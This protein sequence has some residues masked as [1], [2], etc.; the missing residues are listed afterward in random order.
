MSKKISPQGSEMCHWSIPF[1]LFFREKIHA[2]ITNSKFFPVYQIYS[3]QQ[4]YKRKKERGS[5]VL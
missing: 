1:F 4:Y 2:T 3:I 5:I